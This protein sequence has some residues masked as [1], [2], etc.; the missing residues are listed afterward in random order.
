LN[1][2]HRNR[3]RVLRG[4][5]RRLLDAVQRCIAV[6][7]RRAGARRRSVVIAS[8]AFATAAHAATNIV[9]Y[10]Y[11]AAGNIVTMHRSDPAP[12]AIYGFT[13]V[14]GP[15][16]VTVNV[17]GVGFSATATAN[18]VTLNGVP[19]TV[20]AASATTLTVTVPAGAATGRIAVTAG[21]NTAASAQDFVVTAPGVTALSDVDRTRREVT[22]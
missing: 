12:I 6:G 11:D 2:L 16:G 4:L 22:P 21:G 8:L 5:Q 19:A 7:C 18:T 14:T 13:P 3:T 17:A 20:T 10:T 1:N 15:A 9:L